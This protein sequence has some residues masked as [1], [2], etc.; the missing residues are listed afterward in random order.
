[1]WLIG[2]KLLQASDFQQQLVQDGEKTGRSGFTW[3]G[4]SPLKSRRTFTTW[5]TF[6]AGREPYLG[7]AIVYASTICVK[8]YW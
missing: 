1:M 4:P 5:P 8:R 7:A 6:A 2:L 3:N